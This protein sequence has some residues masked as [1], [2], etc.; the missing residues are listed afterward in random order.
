MKGGVTPGVLPCAEGKTRRPDNGV[1]R[2]DWSR[3]CRGGRCQ[4]REYAVMSGDD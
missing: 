3:Q 1:L 4:G 2:D